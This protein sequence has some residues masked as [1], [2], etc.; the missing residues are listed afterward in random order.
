MTTLSIDTETRDLIVDYLRSYEVGEF[1]SFDGTLRCGDRAE[2]AF[3]DRTVG[4]VSRWRGDVED[5]LE[6]ESMN[7]EKIRQGDKDY[8]CADTQEG[9][10][11]SAEQT[12][13]RYRLDQAVLQRLLDRLTP[14]AVV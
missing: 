14:E 9:S 8:Y 3:D 4:F 6:Y 13:A 1:E 12:L 7:L 10:I 2:L 5:N 11:A